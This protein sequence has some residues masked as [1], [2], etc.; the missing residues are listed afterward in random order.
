[1]LKD[2]QLSATIVAEPVSNT[3][4]VS[5]EA[6]LQKQLVEMLAALDTAPAQVHLNVLVLKLP[7]GFAEGCG[8]IAEPGTA[9]AL[10]AREFQMFAALLRHAKER[11]ELDVLSRP[12]LQVCDN[13]TACVQV[14]QVLPIVAPAGTGAVTVEYVPTGH[15]LK[16]T[17]RLLPDGNL[18]IRA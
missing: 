8:L 17:P 2:K 9:C 13:Q 18:L 11:G 15:T 16:T 10:S 4:L 5:V 14:G 7:R 3:V 12:Q 1:F 6:D